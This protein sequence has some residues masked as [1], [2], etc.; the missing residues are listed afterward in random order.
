MIGETHNVCLKHAENLYVLRIIISDVGKYCVKGGD[1]LVD[2]FRI[3]AAF[4]AGTE[5]AVRNDGST[6]LIR[7]CFDCGY[8]CDII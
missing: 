5:V 7:A 8:L 1:H 2:L 4:H 6:D 3:P